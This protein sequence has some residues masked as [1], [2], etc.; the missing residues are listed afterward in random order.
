MKPGQ[1]ETQLFTQVVQLTRAVESHQQAIEEI[2][3]KVLL[4]ATN[5]NTVIFRMSVT[6]RL[7]KDKLGITG[8]EIMAAG[9][10][11]I[12]EDKAQRTAE[13]AAQGVAAASSTVEELTSSPA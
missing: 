1:Q 7:M 6:E 12:E 8:D 5:L 4:L 9:M 10:A 2:T 3:N 13:L 11:A